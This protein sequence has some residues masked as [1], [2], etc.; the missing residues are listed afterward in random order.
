MYSID[1]IDGQN[2]QTNGK[3]SVISGDSGKIKE[4]IN[5]KKYGFVNKIVIYKNNS[6]IN[7]MVVQ[8]PI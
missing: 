1:V 2:V 7:Q 3:G 8:G 5:S 6:K 4:S